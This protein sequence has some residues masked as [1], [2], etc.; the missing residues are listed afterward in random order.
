MAP[1]KRPTLAELRAKP[2]KTTADYQRLLRAER[3]RYLRKYPELKELAE[4]TPER[5]LC[6]IMLIKR[7]EEK[8]AKAA[9]RRA[10]TPRTRAARSA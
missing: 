9:S 8:I 7:Q 1:K 4:T 6:A 10:S 5:V 3:A 2:R